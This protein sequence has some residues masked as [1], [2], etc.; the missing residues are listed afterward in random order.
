AYSRVH[1]GQNYA[2]ASWDDSCSCMTYGDRA[3][4]THPLTALDGAGQAMSHG[5]S[6]HTPDLNHWG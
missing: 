6:S 4:N 3:G 5:V 2:N 1:Y